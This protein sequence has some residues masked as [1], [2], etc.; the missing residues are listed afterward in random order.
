MI[1][2]PACS[3]RNSD[4]AAQC[5][6][7]NASLKHFVYRA[8][9]ACG[10]LNAAGDAFCHRCLSALLP[11]AAAKI[12]QADE[13][14]LTP[15]P[16]SHAEPL[17]EQPS[18]PAGTA[19]EVPAQG[20]VPESPS[21]RAVSV[22]A[23]SAAPPATS[24]PVSGGE[25]AGQGPSEAVAP[26]NVVR[27]DEHELAA[28]ASISLAGPSTVR[29][30]ADQIPS[31]DAL[32][33]GIAAPLPLE[34]AAGL[35]QRV[36]SGS[37]AAPDQ[38]DLYDADL[39]RQIALAPATLHEPGPTPDVQ[40]TEGWF[41]RVGR[42]VL[43]LA[44]LLVALLP[45]FSGGQVNPLVQPREAVSSL[46][47]ALGALSP[48]STVLLS[49]DYGPTYAGEMNTL[50]LDIVRH[51]AGRSVG[52][53]A[54]STRPEGVGLAE[55]I[56]QTVAEDLP[57]YRYGE[58]YVVLGYL[59][60]Q[61]AGLRS[62]SNA[63]G[64]AF[65]TDAVQ[66]Q[67]LENLPVMRGVPDIASFGQIIVISDDSQSVQRWIEQV[68]SRKQVQLGA[69]VA[70]SVEPLLVPYRQTGQLQHLVAGIPA[71]AEYEV[72]SSVRPTALLSTDSYAAWFLLL[73]LVAVTTNVFFLAGSGRGRRRAR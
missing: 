57:E 7:C 59:A 18:H 64:D 4:E 40:R 32:L 21:Q 27:T 8:C 11:A 54:M 43:Y 56:L 73:V 69:V 47:G 15:M 44:V 62:L 2:C 49:F 68:G 28:P 31:V 14:T 58:Q 24:A 3:H 53:V 66:S 34:P 67:P 33:E 60:G 51:L 6:N 22:P 12:A 65:K 71:A 41:P 13:L 10:A 23:Q 61:A 37:D 48:D 42:I 38:S 46:V 26:K 52:V 9:S 63:I 45:T 16:L 35:P 50:A 20:Q 55:H 1:V 39:L 29:A 72:A 17:A 36:A 5:A 30:Q 19:T 70:A 25:K